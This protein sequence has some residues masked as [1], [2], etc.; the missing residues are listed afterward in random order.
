[1]GKPDRETDIIELGEGRGAAFTGAKI[2]TAMPLMRLSFEAHEHVANAMMQ[3]TLAKERWEV[4]GA[5]GEME[6]EFRCV[7]DISETAF[8]KGTKSSSVKEAGSS[9]T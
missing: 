1:M 2:R 7:G 8:S 6:I 3:L 4:Q 9:L 5:I